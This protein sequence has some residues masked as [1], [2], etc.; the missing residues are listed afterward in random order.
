MNKKFY[1]ADEIRWENLGNGVNRQLLGY[2]DNIMMV[3]VDFNKN[4]IGKLHNHPHSQITYILSGIF[5]VT[6]NDETNVLKKDDSFFVSP[7]QTHGVVCKQAGS[8]LD[9]FSP[10]RED[11]L[12]GKE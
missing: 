5:E 3:R 11:F 9:V 7:G 8:L 10:A 6:I 4:S 2:D 12:P 1:L